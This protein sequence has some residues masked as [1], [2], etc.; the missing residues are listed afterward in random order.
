MM[1]ALLSNYCVCF[2]CLAAGC[3]S[4]FSVKQGWGTRGPSVCCPG[5]CPVPVPEGWSPEL[6]VGSPAGEVHGR[7]CFRSWG[8]HCPHER[9]TWFLFNFFTCWII[10]PFFCGKATALVVSTMFL[11]LAGL[12]LAGL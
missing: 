11:Y 1:T 5:L 10:P 7:V 6:C 9:I 8:F 4:Q 12:G 3:G 2:P